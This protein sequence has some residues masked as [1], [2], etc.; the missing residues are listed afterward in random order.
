M[1][2]VYFFNF[3]THFV[4]RC[5]KI[6]DSG[7]S[8]F[9]VFHHWVIHHWL[10]FLG[11][12]NHQPHFLFE[13]FQLHFY[14]FINQ[15]F[16]IFFINASAF[17]PTCALS[18]WLVHWRVW[19]WF[20]FWLRLWLL[21]WLTA[22]LAHSGHSSGFH[23]DGL[24]LWLELFFRLLTSLFDMILHLKY[25]IMDLLLYFLRQWRQRLL[26]YLFDLF[27]HVL[28]RFLLLL[29]GSST[30]SHRWSILIV[31]ILGHFL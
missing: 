12:R 20:H 14:F 11:V 3:I 22:I 25:L 5:F 7:H 15:C 4:Y 9:F 10:S 6:L 26:L 21:F 8:V 16:H 27:L 18:L 30:T 24:N 23:L 28:N 2:L 13:V 31:I 19:I 29:H 1:L 17:A